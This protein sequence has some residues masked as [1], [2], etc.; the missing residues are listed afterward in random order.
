MSQASFPYFALPHL[1]SLILSVGVIFYA[2]KRQNA[3]G[4]LAFI[5]YTGGQTLWITGFILETFN[6]TLS[7]KL[8]WEAVQWLIIL[9]SVPALPL[10]AILYTDKKRQKVAGI[11]KIPLALSFV[12]ALILFSNHI[13]QS[14]FINPQLIV[15]YPYGKLVYER[16]FAFYV[17]SLYI[18][19][20][21]AWGIFLLLRQFIGTH[22]LY[23]AQTA[24]LTIGFFFP[25]LG[26]FLDLT[27]IF[28]IPNQ[29]NLPISIA[30]GN[31]INAWNLFQLKVFKVN[32]VSRD[33]AFEAIMDLV[34]ILDNNN[35]IIDINS[36]MLDLMGKTSAEV[37]GASAKKV[38]DDFPIPIKLYSSVSYA[39]TE[40]SFTV[41]E[42]TVHYEMSVWPILNEKREIVSRLYI[43]HDITALKELEVE[44]RNLN[45]KLETRVRSRTQELADSYDY[46]LEGWA[47]A[48][49]LRDKE[50]E[51]HS[52]RVTEATLKVA[53]AHGV[54]ERD[55]EHIRRGAILHDIGKMA[56][57]DEILMK[58]GNLTDEERRII[59]EHPV[60]AYNLLKEIPYLQKALDI[61]YCHHERWD[62]SGYPRGLKAGEIP[63]AAR[64]FSVV[65]VWDAL[66]SERPYS[67][68]WNA[69]EASAYLI[70]KSGKYFDP[71]IV[72]T[73]LELLEKGE[74]G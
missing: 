73:F 27:G 7:G 47:R 63:L 51:G 22:S 12:L 53:R 55:I 31:L 26:A 1:L 60:I 57:S 45:N 59:E 20:I 23:R 3:S 21:F 69:E 34:V 9:F 6:P 29:S 2:W 39:R 32:P 50:T 70:E 52:R 64:I 41:N 68:R 14:F 40:T 36:S 54:P 10:F 67:P 15:Q 58:P 19:A 38:F 17:F 35:T 13:H 11:I 46:T 56:I 30:L 74:M 28:L 48:L 8:F 66:C 42:K 16:S 33:Q 37:I 62:G 44:L 18:S 24:F 4:A 65:D 72:S 5:W 71:K 49:E 25:A 43:S 61:P